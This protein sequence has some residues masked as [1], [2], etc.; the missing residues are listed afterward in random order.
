VD[1]SVGIVE[2]GGGLRFWPDKVPGEGFFLACFKKKEGE[3]D[4]E[5][6]YRKKPE[7]ATKKEMEMIEKWIK[8][9]GLTFI[10]YLNTV[11]AWPEQFVKDFSFL[12]EQL[13]VI[14]SGVL[15]GELMR[16]KLVPDHALSMSNLVSN[17]IEKTELNYEESIQFL[18]RK[19][20]KIETKNKGW[21]LFT[22]QQHPL[23][24]ANVLA[25]RI[26]N[27]Y[28]KELRILKDS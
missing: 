9:E 7:Q 14:Y 26:N 25:N 13:R 16:D 1:D 8:V 22:Y 19:D 20:L 23:G 15:V 24:W 11:Y 3:A 10:K 18:Q 6:R 17:T 4:A 27:Y 2:S 28:P 5:F 12:L 21:Q